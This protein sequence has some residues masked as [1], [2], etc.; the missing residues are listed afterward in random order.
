MLH[1]IILVQL[2]FYK[3]SLFSSTVLEGRGGG[4][5]E[6]KPH[7][8][9]QYFILLCPLAVLSHFPVII[10]MDMHNS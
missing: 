5:L 9:L 10:F 8:N 3:Y 6:N 4:L 7:F 2:R 1:C